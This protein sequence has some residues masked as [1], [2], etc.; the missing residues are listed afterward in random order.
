MPACAR[1]HGAEY[2]GSAFAFV[3]TVPL[4]DDTRTNRLWWTDFAME[5]NR[6]LIKTHYRFLRIMGLLVQFQHVFHARQI[7]GVDLRQTPHFFP[8]TA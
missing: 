8:A 3:L 2:V 7:R 6:F 5:R 4:G 1:F